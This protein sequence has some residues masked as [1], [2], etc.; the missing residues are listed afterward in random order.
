MKY[1]ASCNTSVQW[2]LGRQFPFPTPDALETIFGGIVRP[3]YEIPRGSGS[4]AWQKNPF[5]QSDLQYLDFL[6]KYPPSGYS[7]SITGSFYANELANS[8]ALFGGIPMKQ[9]FVIN[10]L[11]ALY[12]GPGPTP[13]KI[14]ESDE[15]RPL[16]T[17]CHDWAAYYFHGMTVQVT[18]TTLNWF[19]SAKAYLT[20]IS[21]RGAPLMQ[22]FDDWAA[23]TNAD[24]TDDSVTPVKWVIFWRKFKET[25]GLHPFWYNVPALYFWPHVYDPR[26]QDPWPDFRTP[27]RTAVTA[28]SEY[29]V[30]NT[31]SMQSSHR[32]SDMLRT[33]IPFVDGP[34]DGYPVKG[35]YSN[36][37][38]ASG[39]IRWLTPPG[40]T[41]T[42]PTMEVDI[43]SRLPILV[44]FSKG[45][46][47]ERRISLL[48]DSIV[49]DRLDLPEWGTSTL[50]QRYKNSIERSAL[51]QLTDIML[52]RTALENMN[53][54]AYSFVV[55]NNPTQ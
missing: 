25:S 4:G 41:V 44:R 33:F 8:L 42:A 18:P 55:L 34:A 52:D 47:S 32:L 14:S 37:L 48:N 51:G 26:Y 16:S 21:S 54:P 29:T 20:S 38:K 19:Q 39:F 6:T 12:A 1:W 36:S 27:V 5:V 46:E 45:L 53:P 43:A 3:A 9:E 35:G 7:A 50:L 28:A 23:T 40:P 22:E 24:L 30:D 10:R 13:D 11:T 31:A 17:D 49:S 2:V 15:I